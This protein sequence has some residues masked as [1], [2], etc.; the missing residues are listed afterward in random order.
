[1][2][3][4]SKKEILRNFLKVKYNEQVKIVFDGNVRKWKESEFST[5]AARE[6]RGWAIK[7]KK[8]QFGLNFLFN[9]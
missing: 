1:M 3:W 5:K 6:G 8:Y 7:G 2:L 9:R 4:R